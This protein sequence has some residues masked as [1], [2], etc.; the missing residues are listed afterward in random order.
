VRPLRSHF[1]LGLSLL[2]GSGV[3]ACTCAAYDV[4]VGHVWG[5]F[6]GAVGLRNTSADAKETIVEAGQELSVDGDTRALKPVP[7]EAVAQRLAWA[8][9]HLKDGWLSFRGQT[10]ESVVAEFNQRNERQLIIGD[11]ATGRLRVGGKF[12]V[13]DIDGFVGALA[14][15]HG[16]R[17]VVYPP[18]GKRAEVI[19]LT[20]GEAGSSSPEDM[21]EGAVGK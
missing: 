4:D 21:G 10:L 12:H 18:Q 2:I 3:L 13:T 9:I 19:V 15:T 5:T 8:E 20:G 6:L 7:P 16:V 1:K 14:L 17:A 11:A